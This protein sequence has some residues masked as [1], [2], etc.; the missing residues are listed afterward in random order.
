MS[1]IGADTRSPGALE[2]AS[3]IR[4]GALSARAVTEEALDTVAKWNGRLNCF[5]RV[6]ADEA[7]AQAD[8]IDASIRAGADPG[9]LAGVPFA[10]KNLFDIAG[11]TT[12]A[13]STIHAEQPPASVDATAVSRL[14][15]AGAVLVGALNMDEY[16]YGFT[17][18]NSHDGPTRNPHDPT[19]VAGGSSGGSAA[20]VAAGLVPLTLGSDTNGSI[21][22]PAAFCGIFGLKATYGRIS[23]AGAFLFAESLDHVG[24]F[25][26][27]ARDLAAAFDVL[28]GPDPRDPVCS[29]RPQAPTLNHVHRG[30]EGLRIAVAG[31]F[32]AKQGHPEVFEVVRRAAGA[33]HADREVVFPEAGRAR[34][35]AYVITACEGGQLHL[36]DL[37]ARPQD[38]DPLTIDRFLAG[39]LL[40]AAWYAKAQRFRSWFRDQVRTLF[41]TVDVV[42]APATPCAALTIGQEEFTVDGVAMPARPSAGLFTQPLSFIGL[43]IVCAPVQRAGQMPLG[44]QIIA[45]PYQEEKA[46]RVA[47]ALEQMGIVSA[48]VVRPAVGA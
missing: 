22:V 19:R 40:P 10:V 38:F 12:T 25:A 41:E 9:P 28:H 46:L 15:A 30:H 44:I 47:Y 42:L 27:S 2:T 20:A 7:R 5:T 16:A 14:K 18:E 39:A 26:R 24:P 8:A 43:P 36:A 11:V 13:G 35:A 21:R 17:T 1:T 29:P 31:G 48:P 32:F 45:A 3:L 34:A 23:R 4:E 33:L 6:L 37:K